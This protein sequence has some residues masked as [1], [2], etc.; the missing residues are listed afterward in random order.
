MALSFNKRRGGRTGSAAARGVDEDVKLVGGR[1][2][3]NPG[4]HVLGEM[5]GW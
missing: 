1:R 2:M 5:L 4:H 3:R